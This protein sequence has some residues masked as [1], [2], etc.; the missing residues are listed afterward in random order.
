MEQVTN[1]SFSKTIRLVLLV[2][3][4]MAI[5]AAVAQGSIQVPTLRVQSRSVG[6]EFEL[7][8]VIQPVKQVTISAQAGGRVA[9]LLVK[10]GD[11]VRAGQLLA[12]IDDRETQIGMQRSQAQ[13]AQAQAELRN[14]QAAF[15]RT[16]ELQTKGFVSA[17]A[18]D[19]AD[20]Q[21]KSAMAARDQASAGVKQSAL[22]HGFTRVTAPFDAWVLQ[23][24]AVVGASAA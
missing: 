9:S 10:A 8:V 12:T 4:S 13:V 16:R 21:L 7:E 1:S 24:Q 5:S 3:C 23:T 19:T 14:A 18:L 20:S 15:D 22:A 17:A 11:A 6:S 2:L